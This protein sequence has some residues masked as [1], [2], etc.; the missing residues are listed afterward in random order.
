MQLNSSVFDTYLY[1]KNSS[2]TVIGSNDDSGGST[3]SRIPVTSGYFTLPT[4]G[5]YTIEVS[6]YA[7]LNTGAYTLSLVAGSASSS[8]SLSSSSS[9]SSAGCVVTNPVSLGVASNGSLAITDCTNSARGTSYYTDRFGISV[10]AGQQISILLTSGAFDTYV[11]L[12]SPAGT[13]LVSNDDG[14][15]GTNSRIPATSGTYTVPA[16]GTYIIEVTS[17]SAQVTG[18]YTL[19]VN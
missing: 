5:A 4:T 3:N 10:N 1:L 6:S 7:S 2:G 19:L 15:G 11:Y 17:Y 14:G 16:T 13:V 18:A 8:S 12:K 9:S